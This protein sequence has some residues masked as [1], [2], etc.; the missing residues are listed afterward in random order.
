M[1]NRI[2]LIETVI[3]S[4]YIYIG[5][6]VFSGFVCGYAM[7][8]ENELAVPV[9][10]VTPVRQTMEQFTEITGTFESI[11]KSIL[12]ARV[13]GALVELMGD[14]GDRVRKGALLGLVDPSDYELSLTLSKLTLENTRAHVRKE[15]AEVQRATTHLE[16]MKADL[17][18]IK[19]VF[20]K[21]SFPKQRLD[22]AQNAYETAM[23]AYTKAKIAY[24][25]AK[26]KV[27]ILETQVKIAEKKVADCQ[28]TAPFDGVVTC[29]HVY[30]GEWMV[31]G[32]PVFTL[33][34][35]N[36]IEI[37]AHI[38]EVYLENLSVGMPVSVTVDGVSAPCNESVKT[39]DA[40]LSEI[41]PVADAKRRTIEITVSMEN[42]DFK[43]KPGLYARLRVIFKRS[44]N[45]LT[46]PKSCILNRLG[47]PY[48]FVANS[49]TAH[50]RRIKTGLA[51]GEM[52]EILSGLSSD[53]R[54]V[55]S[56]HKRL[57]GGERLNIQN[58]EAK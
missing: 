17:K 32:K 20:E 30:I 12:S 39:C 18:R 19:G 56:G 27:N 38:S 52:V 9:E 48:V 16:T 41:A 29:R 4:V 46:I 1:K 2:T 22:H 36:P 47:H 44:P 3:L 10:V 26:T 15:Q 28:I 23:A 21:G 31:P 33:E 13:T 35:D 25:E 5:I 34:S 57:Q 54:V 51:E 45:T 11:E 8:Q 43:L 37:K 6:L 40:V 53:A 55:S 24:S 49:D 50:L 58:Q 42:A 14:E 7:A